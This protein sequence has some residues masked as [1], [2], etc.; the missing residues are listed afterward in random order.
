MTGWGRNGFGGGNFGGGN[1]GG[2]GFGWNP[3]CAPA[4][5]QGLSDAFNFNNLDNNQF[6][7]LP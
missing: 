1:D 2:Y 7:I 3:C 5:Q 4:T 6:K